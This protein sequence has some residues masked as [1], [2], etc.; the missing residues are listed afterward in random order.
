M[1]KDLCLHCDV[2]RRLCPVQALTGDRKDRFAKMDMNAC[3]VRHQELKEAG[4]WPCGI[5]TKVCPV[6]ED[7]KFWNRP[8]V[9]RY[10]DEQQGNPGNSP[11]INAWNHMRAFG[12]RV[13][14]R[15]E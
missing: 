7:R 10:F 8:G 1:K 9:K 13:D 4:N 2:C 5:C 11:E 15:G 12:S 6:G 3:T 14:R